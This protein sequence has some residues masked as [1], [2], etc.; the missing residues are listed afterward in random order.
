MRNNIVKKDDGSYYIVR[1]IANRI[2]SFKLPN[3][4]HI[5]TVY[6]YMS[7]SNNDFIALQ[8]M[9]TKYDR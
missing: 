1:S 5:S 4:I 6:E 8:K 3:D 7:L 9:Q 2:H